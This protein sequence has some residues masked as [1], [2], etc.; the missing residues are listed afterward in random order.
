MM[1]RSL[2][3]LCDATSA[4]EKRFDMMAMRLGKREMDL[5]DAGTGEGHDHQTKRAHRLVIREGQLVVVGFM[6]FT[7]QASPRQEVWGF[8]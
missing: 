5:Q 2:A 1:Y 8:F 6:S 7:C 4:A 3:V